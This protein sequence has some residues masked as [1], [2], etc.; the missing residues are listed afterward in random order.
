M[1][2]TSSLSPAG[3]SLLD[4]GAPVGETEEQRKKRLAAIEAQR[5]KLAGTL[6]PAGASLAMRGYLGGL[7]Q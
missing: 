1:N 3:I 7:L 6:S 4:T 2:G 5:Q